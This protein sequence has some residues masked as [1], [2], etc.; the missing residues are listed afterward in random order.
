MFVDEHV[1]G[2]DMGGGR[3][4]D[5]Y[6]CVNWYVCACVGWVVMRRDVSE[7]NCGVNV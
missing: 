7:Y 4:R 3:E 6:L 5:V 1:C 2:V